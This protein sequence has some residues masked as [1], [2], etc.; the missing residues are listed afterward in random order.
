MTAAGSARR[1]FAPPNAVSLLAV[2]LLAAVYFSPF[3][4]L[5]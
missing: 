4:D 2:A 3:G 5:D 1:R